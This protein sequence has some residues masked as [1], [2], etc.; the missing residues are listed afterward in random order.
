M[1]RRACAGGAG[2]STTIVFEP[3]HALAQFAATGCFN[4]TLDYV[5]G[6]NTEV[7]AMEA[8]VE[9]HRGRVEDR[10]VRPGFQ[11]HVARFR[12]PDRSGRPGR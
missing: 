4:G 6:K 12:E 11:P 9:I 8:F 1:P 10:D 7:E 3:K 2:Q 5:M